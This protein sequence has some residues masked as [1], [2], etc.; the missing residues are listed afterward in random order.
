MDE[1]KDDGEY[2]S[3]PS[4]PCEAKKQKLLFFCL[5]VCWVFNAYRI[6]SNRSPSPIEAPTPYFSSWIMLRA[7]PFEKLVVGVSGVR[8]SDHPA[9]T[10]WFF[11]RYP[12]VIPEKISDHPAAISAGQVRP[13]PTL[14]F[15]FLGGTLSWFFFPNFGGSPIKWRW[16]EK[17][18]YPAIVGW[19][20][21]DTTLLWYQTFLQTTPQWYLNHSR[22]TPQH[23][24]FGAPDTPSTDF[25]NGIAL[26]YAN[27]FHKSITTASR[28]YVHA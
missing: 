25:S 4:T 7:I 6:L 14:Q 2:N 10:F 21:C 17:I 23:F 3:P 24:F 28:I 20:G 27:F 11:L 18:D 15:Y 16:A 1:Q 13:P 26:I 19:S 5:L 8:F 12:A 22:T 9:A